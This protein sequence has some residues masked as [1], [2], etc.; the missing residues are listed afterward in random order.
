[1]GSA[2]RGPVLIGGGESHRASFKILDLNQLRPMQL[3]TEHQ[4]SRMGFRI[5]RYSRVRVSADGRVFAS[6]QTSTSPSGFSLMTIDDSIAKVG[7]DHSSFG[8]I[9][10]SPD[11]RRI[12]TSAGI[13]SPKFQLLEDRAKTDFPL[14]AAQG[15]YY[16]RVERLD[17]PSQKE[18]DKNPSVSI[19]ISGNSGPV[20]T[21]PEVNINAG[22]EQYSSRDTIGI[23][24]RILFVPS[25]N[26]IATLPRSNDVVVLRTLDIE[27]QLAVGDIDF[28]FVT[29]R[30][31]E[32]VV[33]GEEFVYQIGVK[34]KRGAVRYSLE[35]A[36][37]RMK[38]DGQGRVTWKAQRVKS[39][40]A[41][42][43]VVVSDASGQ[44]NFHTFQIQV[45]E[46]RHAPSSVVKPPAEE[47][48]KWTDATGNYSVVA[49]FSRSEGD[50]VY[51][52]QENGDEVA[53]EI[54]QLS[55][56]DQQYLQQQNA[57]AGE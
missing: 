27:S 9:A 57:K 41:D 56:Q 34:S 46:K 23:D 10:P 15:D 37:P 36:P 5:D 45:L 13:Y 4:R 6:W 1:M 55:Q 8:H 38:I 40:Q 52:R 31:P 29:T 44:E 24:Q 25:E 14:P 49:T 21:L 28:L 3:T 39:N 50:K 35:S 32:K 18:E 51:L 12:Y 42:V 16:L 30:P 47:S 33:A 22:R 19:Y 48:R 53:I 20:V 54:K 17:R 2:S 43:M 11:G 7:Y 26:V